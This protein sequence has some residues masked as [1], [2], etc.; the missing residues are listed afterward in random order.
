MQM[1]F[2]RLANKIFSVCTRMP[3]FTQGPVEGF[4]KLSKAFYRLANEIF[5]VCSVILNLSPNP[6]QGFRKLSKAF[7]RHSPSF[8]FRGQGKCWYSVIVIANS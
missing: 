2:D 1:G 3:N 5:S 4:R 7:D 8:G 6:F